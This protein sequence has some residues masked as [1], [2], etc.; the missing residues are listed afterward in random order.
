MPNREE[1]DIPPL[2]IR[3]FALLRAEY[4]RVTVQY[5]ADCNVMAKDTLAVMGKSAA[6]GW[7]VRVDLGKAILP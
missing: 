4:Y 2:A 5:E 1:L 3:A 7:I 6:D